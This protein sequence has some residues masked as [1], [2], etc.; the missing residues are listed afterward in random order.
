M[1]R[2]EVDWPSVLVLSVFAGAALG[3][4]AAVAARKVVATMRYWPAFACLGVFI[5]GMAFIAVRLADIN[6]PRF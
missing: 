5:A 6:L 2:R 1:A 3:W 4:A